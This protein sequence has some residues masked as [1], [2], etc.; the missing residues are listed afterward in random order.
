MFEVMMIAACSLALGILIAYDARK[1]KSPD[2]D[3]VEPYFDKDWNIKGFR[4][5]P[6]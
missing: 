2:S 1:W 6:K 3:I 5:K 4:K